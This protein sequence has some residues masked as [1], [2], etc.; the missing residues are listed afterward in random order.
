MS[1]YQ[2]IAGGL[3]RVIQLARANQIERRYLWV[4]VKG[5]WKYARAV[6]TGD[7]AA[8]ADQVARLRQCVPC[9]ASERVPTSKD[10]VIAIYCGRGKRMDDGPTCGCLVGLTIKGNKPDG[11][12]DHDGDGETVPA[13]KTVVASEECPRL[14]YGQAERQSQ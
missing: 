3:E 2:L 14:K 11:T 5:G 9:S 1:I 12:I 7:V 10:G 6:A 8:S 4:A 13:G